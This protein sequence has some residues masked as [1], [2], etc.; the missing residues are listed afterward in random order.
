MKP[1]T[2]M[3]LA[4]M[5]G[6][7][8]P[9]IA[10]A[11]APAETPPVEQTPPTTPS[12]A[13]DAPPAAPPSA[14]ASQTEQAPNAAPTTP[15]AG[16]TSKEEPIV[17]KKKPKARPSEP[18]FDPRWAPTPA[19]IWWGKPFETP[20]TPVE[21]WYGWQTI[22]GLVIPDV[23]TV[24]GYMNNEF[25][26]AVFG[27]SAHMVTGPI[28]HWAHGHVGRGF[29]VLGLNLTLGAVGAL[30]G[31]FSRPAGFPLPAFMGYLAGP[32]LDIAL[33]STEMAK[34]PMV[35]ASNRSPLGVTFGVVPVVDST[36]R[37]LLLTG[38]F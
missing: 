38:Q 7:T 35:R 2:V 25:G 23:L 32:V 27:I 13:A 4:S 34:E 6:L 19:P 9:T 11:Q 18:A 22:L 37:G 10:Y 12:T 36:Q 5:V 20:Q 1:R 26:V 14:D 15:D 8:V 29:G 24:V 30:A 33:F 31:A 28:V 3:L 16:S 21:R 17:K